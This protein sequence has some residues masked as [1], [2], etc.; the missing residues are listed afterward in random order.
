[1]PAS[2]SE[3]RSEV[4]PIKSN[5]VRTINHGRYC[6]NGM[7]MDGRSRII[8]R[9]HH[10][11]IPNDCMQRVR[12]DGQHLTF[13]LIRGVGKSKRHFLLVFVSILPSAEYAHWLDNQ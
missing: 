3:L 13:A 6:A 5:Y 7:K 12:N 9:S 11:R 8:H 1:M 4:E 10:E 2:L